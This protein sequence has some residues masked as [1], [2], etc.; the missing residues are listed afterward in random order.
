MLSL[1]KRPYRVI[2][3]SSHLKTERDTVSETFFFP[4]YLE[5]RMMGRVRKLSDSE[6]IEVFIQ[7]I[8]RICSAFHSVESIGQGQRW[9]PTSF[10]I[11]FLPVTT[12]SQRIWREKHM[13]VWERNVLLM[14]HKVSIDI[15]GRS[16]HDLF[17]SRHH[18]CTTN[19]PL[20]MV[21]PFLFGHCQRFDLG[22]NLF[23][24]FE[25]NNRKYDKII[26]VCK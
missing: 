23:H 2:L 17:I 18:P 22:F 20:W 8:G 15:I 24:K 13:E 4:I 3:P 14:V 5:F 25:I 11:T 10:N 19:F 16:L 1:S 9:Y 6:G 21:P 7:K 12:P 26:P